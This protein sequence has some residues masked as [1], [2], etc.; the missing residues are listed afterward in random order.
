[1]CFIRKFEKE[2]IFFA[3]VKYEGKLLKSLPNYYK[4]SYSFNYWS[5][6]GWKIDCI[7]KFQNWMMIRVRK[8]GSFCFAV[9]QLPHRPWKEMI[10]RLLKVIC[11][12]RV[13]TFI[14][15]ILF[16]FFFWKI[17]NSITS[18]WNSFSYYFIVQGSEKRLFHPIEG[19]RKLH[20][21]WCI[22]IC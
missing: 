17:L 15:F 14:Y 12:K 20:L 6:K 8:K 13:G 1:M 7:N 18:S 19:Y 9:L 11:W 2:K 10:K 4:F 5:Y 16:F 22:I 3:F 21:C